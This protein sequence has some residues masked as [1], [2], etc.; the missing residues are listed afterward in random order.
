MNNVRKDLRA[1]R[2]DIARLRLTQMVRRLVCTCVGQ[3]Q[4]VALQGDGR[5][6][7]RN[8][9]SNKTDGRSMASW[10]NTTLWTP[11]N[12]QQA[13]L[14]QVGQAGNA[15]IPETVRKLPDGR[16]LMGSSETEATELTSPE[17][18]RT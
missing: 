8:L 16:R 14:E 6:E 18:D 17:L 11:H 4:C 1:K 2:V 7:D 12:D 13:F 5:N 15:P 10:E 3:R 9:P